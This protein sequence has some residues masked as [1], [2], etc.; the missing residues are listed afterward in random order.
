MLVRHSQVFRDI[1]D[2]PRPVVGEN[3]EDDDTFDGAPIVELGDEANDIYALLKMMYDSP[4]YIHLSKP[5][6]VPFYLIESVL[7]ASS[8]YEIEQY[9]AWAIARLK[10][11]PAASDTVESIYNHPKWKTYFRNPDYCIRLI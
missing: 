5:E 10:K 2:I 7:R 6:D 4:K 3:G 1:L 9:Q 11:Y 8:K